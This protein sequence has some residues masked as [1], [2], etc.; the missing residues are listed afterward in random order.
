VFSEAPD[1]LI[2]FAAANQGAPTVLSARKSLPSSQRVMEFK[3]ILLQ[4]LMA[5]L[6]SA[7]PE[8]AKTV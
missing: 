7:L 6:P 8:L 4:E 3:S 2:M 1:M 5:S